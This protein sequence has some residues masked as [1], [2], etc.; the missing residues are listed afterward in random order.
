MRLA[1]SRSQ[2]CGRHSTRHRTAP[3]PPLLEL[4]GPQCQ[5]CWGSVS[6]CSNMSQMWSPEPGGAVLPNWTAK[7]PADNI[8]RTGLLGRALGHKAKMSNSSA[9]PH[10]TLAPQA[11][12]SSTLFWDQK[13]FYFPLRSVNFG[14][15]CLLRE[16]CRK[17]PRPS[18]SECWPAWP[19]MNEVLCVLG[20]ASDQRPCQAGTAHLH[21]LQLTNAP[22]S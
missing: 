2:G 14:E 9:G 3:S 22:G 17:S 4:S 8:L 7:L 19:E 10:S 16:T 18:V 21:C 12:H 6:L 1:F 5:W 11:S 15:L 13:I 20:V